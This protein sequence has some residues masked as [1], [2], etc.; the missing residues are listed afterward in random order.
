MEEGHRGGGLRAGAWGSDRPPQAEMHPG[1]Q[2]PRTGKW[3]CQQ[4]LLSI[5]RDGGKDTAQRPRHSTSRH[6]CARPKDTHV[7]VPTPADTSP[8]AAKGPLIQD[9]VKDLRRGMTLHYL[10]GPVSSQ[11][12]ACVTRRQSRAVMGPGHCVAMVMEEGTASQGK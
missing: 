9:Q 2:C 1:P 5:H 7:L 3:G 12:S 6:E 4:E 11:G 8:D 10:G